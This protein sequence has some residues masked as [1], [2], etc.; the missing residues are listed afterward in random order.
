MSSQEGGYSMKMFQSGDCSPGV[1][2]SNGSCLDD[3]LI[4]KIAKVINKMSKKNDRIEP[5]RCD[6]DTRRIHECICRNISKISECSS[7]A[8]ILT[9]REII[10]HLG[11]HSEDFKSSFRPIMPKKWVEDY[12]EWLTTSDI[13]N[14]LN[15]YMEGDPSFYFYGAVPIDFANCSVSNLCSIDVKKHLHKKQDKIGIV[16]NT[17]PHTKGG[18]HWLSMYIDL[19]GKSLHGHPSM[20]YFDSYGRKPPKEIKHLIKKVL[21]QSKKHKMGIQ[22]LYND[23]EYQQRESQCGVYSIHFVEQMLSG[24]TFHGFLN[25]NLNDKK[26]I[27]YRNKYFINLDD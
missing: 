16:F 25:D 12:N 26:M 9:I 20:Y 7:E 11:G 3:E 10:D 17:D 4:I 15:Q 13:E 2:L 8:C 1:D 27:R 6:K 14:V 22:Y 21:K 24:K 19:S 23:E 5:I 18:K